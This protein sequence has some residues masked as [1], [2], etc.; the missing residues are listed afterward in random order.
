MRRNHGESATA[1]WPTA[2]APAPNPARPL[3]C[4]HLAPRRERHVVG[5][6]LTFLQ[7]RWFNP[8]GTDEGGRVPFGSRVRRRRAV[9][10]LSLGCLALVPGCGSSTTFATSGSG[11]TSTPAPS[12]ASTSATTSAPVV[13]Q[14]PKSCSAIP[15]SVIDPYI[16]GVATVQ[17]LAAP[18][19]HVSCEFVNAN[20]SS[21]VIVNIGAGGTTASF[22]TL[23]AQSGQNGR[24]TG[25][26]SGLGSRRRSHRPGSRLF[27]RRAPHARP[28]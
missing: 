23:R 2:I 24:T 3:A 11:A 1:A 5:D 8:R 26:I 17:S 18:P 20:A 25:T 22:A 21:I 28:G 7:P 27:R 15:V 14:P 4:D 9:V 12:S 16:G 6:R 10:A 19:G 13:A